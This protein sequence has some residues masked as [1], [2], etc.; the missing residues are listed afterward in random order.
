MHETANFE[1][2][3]LLP[4]LYLLAFFYVIAALILWPYGLPLLR[5]GE[6]A[7]VLTAAAAMT[8]CA[9]I[10]YIVRQAPRAAIAPEVVNAA[11]FSASVIILSFAS[12]VATVPYFAIKPAI[13]LINGHDYDQA[14]MQVQQRLFGTGSP[15]VWLIERLDAHELHFLD[16]AYNLF[17]P[18]LSLS[19]MIAVY[20]K[21]LRGGVHLSIAQF[22]GLFICLFIALIFPTRGPLF[23]YPAI[24]LPKLANTVSGQLAEY[25]QAAAAEYS[26]DPARVPLLAGIAAMP[27]YHV[28]SWACGLIYWRY[29]PRWAMAIGIA[30]CALDFAS[31]IGLGWH[32]ALDGTVALAL[33]FPVW[34]LAGCIVRVATPAKR[35]R[36]RPLGI[37]EGLHPAASGHGD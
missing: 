11:L 6:L 35:Q 31:T 25:L 7:G 5:D 32:Y 3:A 14:L 23:Q 15:S 4:L 33:V 8:F 21:G 36:A 37:A 2:V 10:L 13:P 1:L 9:A 16:F 26:H 17:M 30:A 27:S 18:F 22:S 29:L 12:Y 20:V 19:L 34:R 28:F 24:Y